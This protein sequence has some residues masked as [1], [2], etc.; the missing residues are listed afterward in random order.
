MIYRNLFTFIY[1]HPY[2]NIEIKNMLEIKMHSLYTHQIQVS[3]LKP[4]L[5][6]GFHTV[7]SDAEGTQQEQTET[8]TEGTCVR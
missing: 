2:K 7:V 4:T 6:P 8:R 5:K 3:K 1:Y